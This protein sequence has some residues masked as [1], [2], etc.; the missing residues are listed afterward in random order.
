MLLSSDS[1]KKTH[2]STKRASTPSPSLTRLPVIDTTSTD[3]SQSQPQPQP[4]SRPRSN[5]HTQISISRRPLPPIPRP[6]VAPPTCLDQ[7]IKVPVGDDAPVSSFP[8][9]KFLAHQSPQPMPRACLEPQSHYTPN[10]SNSPCLSTMNQ[11]FLHGTSANSSTSS[12]GIPEKSYPQKQRHSL[13]QNQH[14]NGVQAQE[15]D[16]VGST[17]FSW[18]KHS[19]R[20][21]ALEQTKLSMNPHLNRLLG[22]ET[23]Y[24]I[25]ANKHQQQQ[26]PC[27]DSTVATN[28]ESDS[29]SHIPQPQFD[30]GGNGDAMVLPERGP[31][32]SP[33]SS[34]STA[35]STARQHHPLPLSAL[36]DSNSHKRMSTPTLPSSPSYYSFHPPFQQ[37]LSP[38][39]TSPSDL[40][41]YCPPPP[42][43]RTTIR[44]SSLSPTF[45]IQATLSPPP[46]A[47]ETPSDTQFTKP[48]ISSGTMTRLSGQQGLA[49]R[50][51][52]S[53]AAVSLTIDT[54]SLSAIKNR[55]GTA[56]VWT[57]NDIRGENSG[58]Q[59]LEPDT[60]VKRTAVHLLQTVGGPKH[61]QNRQQQQHFLHQH[62]Q[63]SS[64]YLAIPQVQSSQHA[65]QR[66]APSG[67]LTR[68]Q[69]Q[70]QQYQLQQ[71]QSRSRMSSSPSSPECSTF[72]SNI[73]NTTQDRTAMALMQQYLIHPD[74]PDSEADISMQVMISQAAVDSK[75]FEILLPEAVDSIKRIREAA[76]SLLKL[77]A[78]NKKLAKQASE[79]L[80]A[81]N[82]KVDQVATEL[83]KLTQLAAELQRTILQHTSGVLAL[84]VV[85][86]EDQG[87]RE[88]EFHFAQIQE[89][90]HRRESQQQMESMSKSIQDLESGTLEAQLLLADK[91]RAI[92]RLTKQLEHQREMYRKM[93]EHQQ[94]TLSLSR[95]QQKLSQDAST[96][97]ETEL[98]SF[99]DLVGKRLQEILNFQGEDEPKQP[100]VPEHKKRAS[101][102]T[103]GSKGSN[104]TTMTSP[105]DTTLAALREDSM[106]SAP[107]DLTASVT[108][109]GTF[110]ATNSRDVTPTA[111]PTSPATST[112]R[113]QFSIQGITAA[114]DALDNHCNESSQKLRIIES[115]LSLLRRQS[116][117]I[118]AS[119]SNSIQVKRSTS[120]SRVNLQ[121]QI[122]VRQA[123]EDTIR[124]ALENSL[125]DA[126]LE[127]E[128]ARQELENERQRWQDDQTDRI[129]AL[130]ESLVAVEK[131]ERMIAVGGDVVSEGSSQIKII[132]ELKTQLREAVEEIEVLSQ[133]HQQSLISMRQLFNLVPDP[134]R[135]CQMQL[136]MAYQ[137][138]GDASSPG[139]RSTPSSERNSPAGAE[140]FSMDALMVRIKELMAKAH[141]FEQNN[142]ELR[143]HV[144]ANEAISKHHRNTS[145]PKHLEEPSAGS[146][147]ILTPDLEKLQA[148]AGMIHLLEKELQLLKQHTDM[149]LDENTRLA[150]LVA[151]STVY[152]YPGRSIVFEGH[153]GTQGI[154]KKPTRDDTL[155]ELREVIRVKE[156]LL[157]ERDQLVQEQ[158]RVIFKAR[159]DLARIQPPT[160]TGTVNI[161]MLTSAVGAVPAVG[162]AGPMSPF[163]VAALEE[164]RTRCSKIEE[165]AAE[166]R[167]M[168]AALESTRG[169]PGVGAR[170]LAANYAGASSWFSS[171]TIN[172][173]A[174]ST[175]SFQQSSFKEG[176]INT[177]TST[178]TH[179]PLQDAHWKGS[180]ELGC[181]LGQGSSNSSSSLHPQGTS[182][183]IVG[184]T[185]ALRKEFRRVMAELRNEKEQSVR[186]EV[187]ER[188]RLERVVRQLRR[189]LQ[190]VQNNMV[191]HS[192]PTLQIIGG[193]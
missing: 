44:P 158:E 103:L 51:R 74:D 65:G 147:W 31:S 142:E 132:Q 7:K 59:P 118:N 96:S 87:R 171:R 133:Q 43:P 130:E 15:H 178:L 100:N 60:A 70:L 179:P 121:T 177:G 159:E 125:K 124:A 42:Q 168:L 66:Q 68:S 71:H 109:K 172:D 19:W 116:I 10:G 2:F 58:D 3:S 32:V 20:N 112:A 167:L 85:R 1:S 137:E 107:S 141:Q 157:R 77:H 83:W 136:F 94:R 90:H 156:R 110:I 47:Q 73:L 163:D 191:P 13:Q 12:S 138:T 52:H 151:N 113:S 183:V 49:R 117:A 181:V 9:P 55:P 88:R 18:S 64:N 134:R 95:S 152:S 33:C 144:N 80:D 48:T 26:M 106:S 98:N 148:S 82:R 188:R 146:T 99:L 97:K 16:P 139:K 101:Q 115:E 5:S 28:R 190:T 105:Y 37:H 129:L 169:G 14:Q 79:H 72:N 54:K 56:D 174:N 92:E 53:S 186:K 104:A 17:D 4:G 193:D 162:M 27:C 89:S 63:Q 57:G 50:R 21:T 36:E 185:A 40:Q 180:L 122:P 150:E 126:V 30:R 127:K 165:E 164:Y 140:S 35:P 153:V 39:L 22:Q 145:L 84:G 155:E 62:T 11:S 161:K 61:H 102:T 176:V 135:N 78:D 192:S 76:Q 128:M 81:A 119:R 46:K 41:P 69:Q 175:P 143:E 166:M 114:L 67:R 8:S 34:P 154:V 184:A 149:L 120:S 24:R 45:S 173:E 6:Y 91:D 38:V 187:E 131:E 25:G 86:L 93:D 29:P 23:S 108:A 123:G 189:E 160:P 182:S 75:N 111:A 170:T